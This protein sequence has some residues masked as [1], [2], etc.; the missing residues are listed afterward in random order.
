[1]SDVDF[2]AK[3]VGLKSAKSIDNDA[4]TTPETRYSFTGRMQE[5]VEAYNATVQLLVPRWPWFF[6]PGYL[7]YAVY[8]RYA[9]YYRGKFLLT[10]VPNQLYELLIKNELIKSEHII[11]AS[12]E[13]YDAYAESADVN[14]VNLIVRGAWS[15]K[16]NPKSGSVH[17]WDSSEVVKQ[18]LQETP[19]TIVAQILPIENAQCQSN[20]LYVKENFYGNLMERCGN[21][22]K[23]NNCWVQLDTFNDEQTIPTIA[24][25]AQVYLLNNP[26][27]L[28]AEVSELIL[29]N[30]FNTP[31][32]LHRGHI[33]RIEVNAQLVGTAAFAHYY[34]IFAY[35]REVYFRCIHLE[36]KG[37]EFEVQAVV[38]KNFSNLV[39]VPHVHSFL[40]RQALDSCAI[41]NNYPS[42]LRR[43]YQM[44]RSSVD[45]FL[46]KRSACLSSKHI[47]PVFLL[48]G[49]R[50]SGKTKLI[51]AVAQELGMH[52]YGADCAEI[53]SQV[54]SHTEMKLKAVFAKSQV[55]EPL[56][57]CFHNFEIFGIDNEG[58][59]DLRLLSAFHVQ[60]QELFSRDRKYPVVVVAL[61]S[62]RH[63]KPM[64]QSLFLEIIN[65]E[66]PN[67]SER[68]ELLKWMHVR[69]SFN[70]AIYN[71]KALAKLPLFP[72]SMQSQYMSKLCPQWGIVK[73]VLEEVATKSQG[74]MLG[75]LQLLYDNAV[76]LKR[77]Q[78][79]DGQTHLTLDH[80]SKNLN[81]MQSSFADSLGAPKVPKVYWS[82]IGGLSKLKDEIQSSIGLPLKHVHL[83]GK[84]LRRSGILLY[85][86]PG[87]GKTLVA[88]AVA[89]ECNLSFLSVQGP[90]LLNMYVGQSEQNVREVFTRAR[91]A[92]PC[93]LF[94]DELDS[95]A[96]NRGVAGD[97][98]G[99]MD[100]VVSQLLAEMDG[101][102]SGDATKPI[103]ILAATNRPDLIDPALLRPGRFDKLFYV[104]PC[105]TP[106]DKAA[107]LRAQTQRFNLADD[108]D[109]AQ[110]AENLK[111]EMSGADLYSIC[112][113]AW[114]SAVRRIIGNHESCGREAKELS[115]E[116]II[117]ESED[118]TTSFRKFVPSISQSDL[119]YFR[120][121]KETYSV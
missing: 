22:K 3:K 49:D 101:M 24:T 91:S 110:I 53:V 30:Y 112:S 28:P 88:K 17:S 94:L 25:K 92:A 84:N 60:I 11:F 69:E 87:T 107:V 66:A 58:N 55:S 32:M 70:D 102:S 83:M 2:V 50:G 90:E 67:Q 47:F 33:Y 10:P 40:P 57:I 14:F 63:L 45:A 75:D 109:L 7:I 115:A 98:G 18:I 20:C 37:S 111:T 42:G 43:P 13:V 103:F 61:T 26:H 59:E 44:L 35:L 1:M 54:P 21:N 117:V 36:A 9:K 85:G 51:T 95:L 114:L 106:D 64:I 29:S 19:Y 99:V 56:I 96:P 38:A 34:L 12:K 27:E 8:W 89:T 93:V 120:N 104:G 82:D 116:H 118:F 23:R 5:L 78:S 81:D 74:F 76:R 121:L 73:D 71:Q 79:T 15:S 52:L 77:R 6:F 68:F 97:S 113:N 62:D 39:Q 86:P 41:A 105:S 100:R 16:A 48:Q 80:F 46:P 108:V 72:L 119:E 31:R 4:A 65:I